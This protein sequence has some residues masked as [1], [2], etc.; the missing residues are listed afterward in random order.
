MSKQKN[1]LF[2]FIKISFKAY[3]P[4]YVSLTLL[5]LINAA[6]SIFSAY[7]VSIIIH[8]IENGV[9][10]KAIIAGIIVTLI[11]VLLGLIRKFLLKRNELHKVGMDKAINQII[12][13]KIM[14]LPFEY[15]ENPYYLEL[16][17]NAEMSISNF[18][19]IYGLMNS[20]AT[21]FSSILSLIGLGA[22]IFTFDPWLILVMFAGIILNVIL[23]VVST[24]E[25]VSFYK[26]LIP[27]NYK[28]GYYLTTL[29]SGENA[30][31]FR[32]Y[33]TYDALTNNFKDYSNKV[34]K[35]FL[36]IYFKEGT[37]AA[38]NSIVRYVQMGF[39]YALV[40]IKTL[41]NKLPVS[42]FTLTVSAAINFSS[43]ITSMIE[44]SEGFS[45]YIE[46]IKPAIE[47]LET[48]ES[49]DEGTLDLKEIKTIEFKNVYFTYPNTNNEVLTNVSFKIN[50]NEKISLVGLNGAGKTTIIKLLCRLYKPNSGEILINDIPINEYDYSLYIK[51]IS[52]I[53]QDYK[54]FAYS[55][56]ENIN[57]RLELERIEEI[58]TDVGLSDTIEKLPNKYESTLLKSYE[59]D[60]I[61]LSGGQRQKIAIARALAKDSSLLIL[62][63]PTSALDPLAEA[64][65]YE[66]FNSLAKDKMA[67]YISHRMSSSIFCDRILILDGGTITDFDTHENLMKKKDSLY[68]KLFMS[69]ANN[70]RN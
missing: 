55:I 19:T 17:K 23:I 60:S 12:A 62:D 68:Y 58:C 70:Y 59:E 53:F 21:L 15:L 8:F 5:S 13:S 36:G 1:V 69:Q 38:F 37:Y 11:E 42:G 33:K 2:K 28:Y 22:I 30:K 43:S 31:D 46:Y 32:F 26:R 27:I 49:K 47:L 24:K 41:I 51:Q 25:R 67:I 45:Q 48:K 35:E 61:E 4:Y 52:A 18:S 63:E 14:S 6:M 34:M 44:A 10:K 3:K 54:L 20:F 16:K 65:I 7:S 29:M 39:I 40:G 57:E 9:Y 66:N 50:E 64:E 56:R